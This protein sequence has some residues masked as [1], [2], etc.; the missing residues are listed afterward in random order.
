MQKSAV[1]N[2]CPDYPRFVRGRDSV[3]AYFHRLFRERIV[4][5]DGVRRRVGLWACAVGVQELTS[6]LVGCAYLSHIKYDT[7]PAHNRPWA[8]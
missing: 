3:L 1:E 6:L 4:I 5:Y 2:G 7:L 8:Q